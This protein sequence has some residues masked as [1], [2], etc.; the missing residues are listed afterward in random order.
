MSKTFSLED[1]R[2]LAAVL[3]ETALAEVMPRFRN[4]PDGSVRG[5]SSPRDL[6][7]DADE[8]AERMIGARLAKLHPGAVLIGEEASARNPAL[9]NMLVDAD[10]AFLIDP[11]DGTR[12]Y[13]AGL[14]LFGMM[15]AACHRG[16]VIA[17]VIYDPVNRDSALAVRGEGAWMEYDNG[18][19]VPLTVAA[20]APLEDMDGLISTGALP[21]PLRTTVNSHLSRLASTASLRCAAHEYRM[22]AAGHCHI[23]L[24]NQL[25]AWDHAAG[26]LLHREA[27]GYAAR[28]DGSPYKPTHRTGGLL[29]APDAGSW[30]AARKALLGEGLEGAEG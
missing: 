7:T 16:D 24:Y 11:I 21:E 26:W 30:H 9:L 10:L 3:A 29:Y 12:N 1:T 6:V 22:L 15:I 23:A 13:V 4:L 14:P 18:R 8:A 2:K 27:G 17:G 25:T 28:F 19:R 5:K 20:P